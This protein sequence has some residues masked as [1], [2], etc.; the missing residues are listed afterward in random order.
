MWKILPI[1]ILEEDFRGETMATKKEKT[2]ILKIDTDMLT[3]EQIRMIKTLHGQILNV[4][5]TDDESEYFN[6]S[7]EVMRLCASLI[8]KS[9]FG[10]NLKKES[11]IP[12][13]EQALEFSVDSLQDQISNSKVIIYDN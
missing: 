7:S 11:S 13:A 12:Y 5:T 8:K 9:F 6:G 1:R 4:V 2:L 10:D 3:Q